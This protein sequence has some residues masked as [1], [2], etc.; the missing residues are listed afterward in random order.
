MISL[1]RIF[2]VKNWAPMLSSMQPI[3]KYFIVMFLISC[4]LLEIFTFVVYQQSQVSRKSNDWVIHSYEVMRIGRLL[5]LDAVDMANNEQ[6]LLLTSDS[7][8]IK[9]YQQNAADVLVKLDEL[10]NVT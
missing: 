7:S 8:Y 9:P 4:V 1:P 5:M 10:D 3:K 2:H 6:E